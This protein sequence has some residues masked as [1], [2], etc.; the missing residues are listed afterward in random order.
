MLRPHPGVELKLLAL[1]GMAL[2]VGAD[3]LR[4]V[5][6]EMGPSYTTR[7]EAALDGM[8]T[9]IQAAPQLAP[10]VLDLFAKAQDWPMADKI[11][12]R[13]RTMLPPQIQAQEAEESGEAPPPPMPPSPQEQAAMA[14]QERQQ[15]IEAGRQQLDMEKLGVER[16]K[17]QAD[18]LK[19]QAEI[20]KAHL[21]AQA[22]I[23]EANRPQMPGMEGGAPAADPQIEAIGAAVAQLSEV[24]S[25][26][27][28]EISAV[29]PPPPA[30]PAEPEPPTMALPTD[31]NEA[32][33]GA[34][35]FDP[36]ALG[37]PAPEMMG[38]P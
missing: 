5:A 24:V 17:L 21:D 4:D 3:R 28:E 37:Q 23:M 25:M 8:V 2:P 13:I 36:G 20:E 15:Q 1:P 10:V 33:P 29:Q 12:K 31:F 11:A 27:L 32:P 9:L 34:F 18:V 16:E 26:I 38:Q 14:Q 35:S 22:R 19:I 7:R 6:M 30:P